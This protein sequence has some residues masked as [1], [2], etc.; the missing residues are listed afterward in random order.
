M[1]LRLRL[2][3]D[4]SAL[5]RSEIFPT[6]FHFIPSGLLGGSY[7]AEQFLYLVEPEIEHFRRL[8]TGKATF[9]IPLDDQHLP[10]PPDRV[11]SVQT[12]QRFP[13]IWKLE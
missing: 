12:Q 11:A 13:R 8:A 10:S 5:D 4:S 7:P 6:E 3:R 1:C 2:S 9:A